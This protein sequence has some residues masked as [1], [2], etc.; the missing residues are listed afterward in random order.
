MFVSAGC[1]HAEELVLGE[2]VPVNPGVFGANNNN[3]TPENL[4]GNAAYAALVKALEVRH[5]RYIGG[6]SA[7]FWDWEAG[8][9]VG[10]DEITRIWP[11]NHGNW[12][13]E[14]AAPTAA[15]PPG[16]LGPDSYAAFA[17]KAGV[18][19]QWLVNLTT[20]HQDQADFIRHLK[21]NGIPMK[22]LE[23]DNETYFWGEEFHGPQGAQVYADRV[24][25]LTSVVRELFPDARIG[26]VAWEEDF[27]MEHGHQGSPMQAN[28]NGIIT[29][30][31]N[32]PYFDA[33]ILHHYVMD[34]GRLDAYETKTEW[35]RAF[36]AYPQSTLERAGR[37]IAE[38]Y[39]SIP[40]WITE[41]N[42]IGY[43]RIGNPND[44]K[45]DGELTDQDKWIASTAHT[46]WNALY[47]AGFWLTGLS[48]P[49]SIEILNHHS[50]TNMKLGWGLG[51]YV[52]EN[53]GDISATGQL[54]S[55]LSHLAS[56]HEQMHA[57]TV[58]GNT[59]LNVTIE[60]DDSMG[61][62]H[63]AALSSDDRLTYLIINR[64]DEPTEATIPGDDRFASA[65][66]TTYLATEP[67]EKTARVTYDADEAVWEQ[68]PMHPQKQVVVLE[69]GRP[70]VRT[71]PGYSLSIVELKP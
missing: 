34:A 6:S 17:K 66:V 10:E 27:F 12:M 45:P 62:L 68:G 51:M 14:L 36:L 54:F 1:L 22:Y 64:S 2:G 37:L 67:I 56:Q 57:V 7:S 19:V 30:S 23:M 59:P 13:L 42:V 15:L 20:R 47:Q 18:T 5:L 71:L 38:R 26:I 70:L 44:E 11:A 32:M 49:E 41:Y 21:A 53:H 33:F 8:H 24:R 25:D 52:D 9:Y 65:Q 61:A 43:Y 69:T 31:Q 58:K 39:G 46:G 40:M 63:A 35:C 3:A 55:H 29:S 50:V 28:W 16:T 60:G 4:P 48:R